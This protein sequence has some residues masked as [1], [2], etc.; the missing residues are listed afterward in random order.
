V[1][2]HVGARLPHGLRDLIGIERVR[3]HRHGAQVV[4]HRLL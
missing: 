2:D 1:D 4:E 3:D